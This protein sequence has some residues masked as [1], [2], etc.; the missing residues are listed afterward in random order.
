MDD[1]TDPTDDTPAGNSA[2][3]QTDPPAKPDAG[4]TQAEIDKWK[5]Q[6]RKHEARAREN[7]DAAARLKQIEDAAKSDTQRLTDDLTTHR[8]RADT[9]EA[10]LLK[11]QVALDHAPDGMSTKRIRAL[12][13]RLQG[14]T[15]EELEA[16]AAELFADFI[17]AAGPSTDP[18]PDPV[19]VPGR[20]REQYR[21]GG[22]DPT[23][24]PEETDPAKL[25]AMVPRAR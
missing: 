25:A 19:K 23:E 24:E 3:P 10:G 13:G 1:D 21:G 17:P 18:K 2:L 15:V 4:S 7:A 6:S 16:D 20:P 5:A 8:T 9:A 11:L 12:A 22:G 14:A